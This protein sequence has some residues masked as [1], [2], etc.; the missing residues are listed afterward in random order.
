MDVRHTTG[1]KNVMKISTF[2]LGVVFGNK[3]SFILNSLVA[4]C[5]NFLLEDPLTTYD[6]LTMKTLIFGEA[7]N[8]YQH[9]GVALGW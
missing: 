4:L 3:P 7:I 6:I 2:F 9:H 5:P 8:H 1:A